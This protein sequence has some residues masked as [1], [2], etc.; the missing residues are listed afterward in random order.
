MLQ[1][2]D[3]RGSSVD[4]PQ[5]EPPQT[6]TILP[7]EDDKQRGILAR[8]GPPF[9]ADNQL[10]PGWTKKT[11]WECGWLLFVLHALAI[12]TGFAPSEREYKR[13]VP[14]DRT[15]RKYFGRYSGLVQHG[16]YKTAR[17]RIR[18][19]GAQRR[20]A[21]WEAERAERAARALAKAKKSAPAAASA[22]KA[23]IVERSFVEGPALEGILPRAGQAKLPPEMVY[24]DRLHNCG[25]A[26]APV[27]EQGVVLLFGML[28]KE[29]NFEIEM[30][31]T[32]YPDCE[33]KRQGKDGK[34]R[35]V[36]IE[37]EFAT[38]RFDHD[39]EG[40][41]LIVCWEDD[42]NTTGLEV[43]ELKKYMAQ[44]IDSQRLAAQK[45]TASRKKPAP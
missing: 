2:P 16:G 31:R 30:V 23:S 17:D 40:C 18:L 4:T 10:R 39:P 29:L 19:V 33:A 1:Q 7:E 37:F 32:A 44:L 13:V 41:D 34:W 9:D 6:A 24:G 15:L 35:K 26:H 20:N 12:W 38:S 25:M 42:R 43:L 8:L 5:T 45:A 11:V 36:L 28:A 22:S 3:S 27:N 21:I 14:S